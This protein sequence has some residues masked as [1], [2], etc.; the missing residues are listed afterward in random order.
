MDIKRIPSSDLP[1]LDAVVKQCINDGR[2]TLFRTRQMNIDRNVA[3]HIKGRDSLY[4]LDASGNVL[5]IGQMA[6]APSM[7]ELLYFTDLPSPPSLS[8]QRWIPGR[9][10]E[11]FERDGS[12]RRLK[13]F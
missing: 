12:A 3:Y 5:S 6:D 7:D 13:N 4:R 9:T 10:G 2:W 8:E 11:F 1:A